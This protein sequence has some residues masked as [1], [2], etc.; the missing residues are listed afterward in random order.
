MYNSFC[1]RVYQKKKLHNLQH[2]GGCPTALASGGGR[3]RS[4]PEAVAS[5]FGV[6]VMAAVAVPEDVPESLTFHVPLSVPRM[7]SLGVEDCTNVVVTVTCRRGAVNH[8]VPS[9]SVW[10]PASM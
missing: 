9:S 2:K 4:T 3:G 5:G 8:E 6:A 10:A 1:T 7:D